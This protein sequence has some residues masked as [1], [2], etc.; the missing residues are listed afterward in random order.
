M[1]VSSATEIKWIKQRWYWQIEVTVR[2]L[3]LF[4]PSLCQK[5]EQIQTIIM[6]GRTTLDR[7][8]LGLC[9][10]VKLSATLVIWKWIFSITL[11]Q[12]NLI[13]TRKVLYFA[14]FWK[15]QIL[16]LGN[17]LLRVRHKMCHIKIWKSWP[18]VVVW[19]KSKGNPK[20]C[21]C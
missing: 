6:I 11:M 15:W 8:A 17:G 7:V 19:R 3:R 2:V 20:L 21:T 1:K 5:K 12:L 14:S 10:K 16:D 18:T 13:F 4:Y 9:F